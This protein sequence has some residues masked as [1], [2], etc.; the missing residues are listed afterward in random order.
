M[1]TLCKFLNQVHLQLLNY[2]NPKLKQKLILTNLRER[3]PR[4][5]EIWECNQPMQILYIVCVTNAMGC[6]QTTD[7][8]HSLQIKVSGEKKAIDKFY[9]LS[10]L[11]L[12]KQGILFLEVYRPISSVFM[13]RRNWAERLI[14]DSSFS[15]VFRELILSSQQF[16]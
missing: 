12:C 9:H 2:R 13:Q 5:V 7:K 10:H 4:R 16:L 6:D 11:K 8:V 14:F 3:I 1:Q 15:V